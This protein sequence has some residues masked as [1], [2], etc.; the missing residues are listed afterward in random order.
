MVTFLSID[1]LAY[2]SMIRNVR[3]GLET[4]TQI[5]K[6]L[7]PDNWVTTTAISRNVDVTFTTVLYH[8]RNLE[9]ERIVERN[10]G[11]HGWRFGPFQQSDLSQYLETKPSRKKKR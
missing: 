8:L 1:R 6:Q 11:G 10:P 9:R 5:I 3:R 4:R 2:L 7:D